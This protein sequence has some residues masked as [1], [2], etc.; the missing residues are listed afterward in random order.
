MVIFADLPPEK[1]KAPTPDQIL[2]S[3]K[4]YLEDDFKLKN[5]KA[6]PEAFG[7]KKYPAR[8]ITGDREQLSLK[9]KIVLVGNRLY[10]VY[11][12]GPKD[13]V[14]AKEADEFLASFAITD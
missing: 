2:D 7:P 6:D 11:A 12:F 4:K 3:G 5:V 1:L 13:F 8:N 10:Q 14:S 9:G